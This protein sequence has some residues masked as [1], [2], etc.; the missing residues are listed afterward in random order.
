MPKATP[1]PETPEAPPTRVRVYEHGSVLFE[2]RVLSVNEDG[3][4]DSTNDHTPPAR[5]LYGVRARIGDSNG[6]ERA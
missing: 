2:A 6:W 3:T 5:V 4:L 1:A